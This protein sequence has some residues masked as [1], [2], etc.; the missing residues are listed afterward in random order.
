MPPAF[1]STRRWHQCWKPEKSIIRSRVLVGLERVRLEGKKL[2]RPKVAPKVE[3][4]SH[5][6]LSV[7]NGIL[8]LA[9]IDPASSDGDALARQHSLLSGYMTGG[10]LKSQ[11][12]GAV[13][14]Q[15]RPQR[16]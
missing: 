1:I 5:G 11:A 16:P 2:N 7:G 8:K 4:A 10:L 9:A 12:R 14:R 6:H 13:D 15:A 3:N